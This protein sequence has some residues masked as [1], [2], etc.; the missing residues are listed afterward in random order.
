VLVL[1]S[2]SSALEERLEYRR[3]RSTRDIQRERETKSW[4]VFEW[5]LKP[6]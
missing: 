4:A 2:L 5:A 6:T 3:K 1:V